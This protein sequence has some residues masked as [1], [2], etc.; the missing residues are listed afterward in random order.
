MVNGAT[1]HFDPI[2]GVYKRKCRVCKQ[3]FYAQVVPINERDHHL[4][5]FSLWKGVWLDASKEVA[6]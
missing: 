5:E 4:G 6:K 3:V 2:S 1:T